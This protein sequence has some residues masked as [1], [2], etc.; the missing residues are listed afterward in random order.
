MVGRSGTKTVLL[1]WSGMRRWIG[2]GTSNRVLAA[3]LFTDIIDSTGTAARL[4]DARWHDILTLHYHQADDAIE[5]FGGRRIVTTGDGLLAS[6]DAAVAAVRCATAIRSG[7]ARQD[8]ALRI[9]I[10]VGEVELAGDDVR[11]ITVHQASRV[12]SAAGSGEIYATEAVRLLCQGAELVF[13][14]AGEHELKG[15]A[16]RWHLYRTCVGLH[17]APSS[18][19]PRLTSCSRRDTGSGG[20]EA[21]GVRVSPLAPL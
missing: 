20:R 9:G 19:R 18:R 14:D 2:G 8:L 3:L 4:G 16:E 21:V 17:V 5:R 11:G 10:H 15:V 6:F 13:E 12:M 1:E 7:A